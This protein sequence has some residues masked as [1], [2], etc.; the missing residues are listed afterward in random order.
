MNDIPTRE[1]FYWA[2]WLKAAPGTVDEAELGDMSEHALWEVVDVFLNGGNADDP[3]YLLVHVPGVQKAQPRE[4][5][6][7]GNRI[8]K[9]RT[10]L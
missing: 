6:E 10:Y 8:P 2:R 5:F 1:G 9:P 4:N 3:E 7:W